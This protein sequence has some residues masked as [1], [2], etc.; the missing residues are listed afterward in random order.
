MTHKLNDFL[1][2]EFG[3]NGTVINISKQAEKDIREVFQKIDYIQQFNQLKVI[4]AMQKNNV[5]D[6]HFTGTTGYGYDD[7]GREVL[8][9][10]YADIFKAEDAMVRHQISAGTH[11]LAICM[12]GNLRPGDELLSI[13][14]KP[15]DTLE[16]VI[17]I[18][19]E[20]GGSL[21]EFGIFY[22]QVDLL[23]DGSLDFEGIKTQINDK[24]KMVF[25]QRSRGYCWRPPMSIDDI[26]K[27]VKLVKSIKSDA[28]IMVDNCYGEFVEER[29]PVEAG[30]D[31]VAGSLIKNPGGGLAPSGGYIAGKEICVRKAAYRLTTPG[32]GKEIGP[33][34]G[35]NRLLFQGL[36]L[37]PHV[38]SESLKGAVFCASLMNKLGF[39]TSPMPKDKRG[40][41]IQAIKFNNADHLIA[42]C[43][44]IQ[45]GSPVD[46]FV[47][48]Q[49]WDMP[50][51]DSPVIM[52]AGAFV[53]GS[54][55][56]LSADAPIKPP[57]I[58]YMQGGLVY[59]HVKLGVMIA[60]QMMMDRG[61]IKI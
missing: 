29:E 6:S 22:R 51:Y 18:R 7:R 31:I 13:T 19:G 11:A 15:Y 25:I 23:E 48:P 20:G 53:Q 36:F 9:A 42:F 57:Y 55:I 33:S 16:E 50:G 21:K 28:I 52:A 4:K 44:G 60:V 27:A 32:L 49:P 35:H 39:E 14:G 26:E 8:D 34:L 54:S 3:I 47:T 2:E 43:Q 12:Y 45:K 58:A 59:E 40:D 56:E 41:I 10:V 46:A 38:V 24:T 37:A 61:I 5:S 17:G 30:V 1:D